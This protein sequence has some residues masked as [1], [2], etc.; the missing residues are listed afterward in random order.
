MTSRSRIPDL[1]KKYLRRVLGLSGQSWKAP[2][3]FE[4]LY[5]RACEKCKVPVAS[6][7][8]KRRRRFVGMQ[9]LQALGEPKGAVAEC[10]CF[11]GVSSYLICQS[12]SQ[13]HEIGKQ[14]EF[15]IFDSFEGLSRR[16]QPDFVNNKNSQTEALMSCSLE[17]V[18]DN[19]SEFG[20]IH[21]HKGWI[22]HCFRDVDEN[23]TFS[24]VHIDLDLYGPVRDALNF[25]FPRLSCPGFIVVDD[26]GS[27][28]WPGV[29]K[30]VEE[31]VEQQ[32][33]S[34]IRSTVGIAVIGKLV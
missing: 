7:P 20:F 10:G 15:H 14:Q 24:F 22:P 31:F 28:K 25:F 19:L 4:A 29:L 11:K 3:E 27:R 9:F 5:D 33:C 8:K 1:A 34:C 21:Y 30:A 16:T 18:K 13:H 26:Y 23:K 17:E 12:L 2:G 6:N 32:G